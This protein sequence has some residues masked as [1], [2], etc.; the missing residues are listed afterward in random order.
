MTDALQLSRDIL[1]IFHAS[2]A[3]G[4]ASC[5]AARRHFGDRAD[6][7]PAT[8]G[9][10]PPDVT[11]KDIYL[12]DFS[13]KLDPMRRLI[14]FNRHVTVLDHHKTALEE[15]SP[16][17]DPT[18]KF[19]GW[20]DKIRLILDMNH[21]GGALAWRYFHPDMS[22]PWL[23]DYTEARDLWTFHL[24][25]SR[26]I[27][28]FLASQPFDHDLWDQFSNI[29]VDSLGWEVMRIEGRAILRYQDQKVEEQVRHASEIIIDGHTVL[30][31]NATHLISE[32]ANRLAVGRAFGAC[33]FIRGDGVKVWS[34]RST[35]GGVDVSE[36]ARRHGGGG[37]ARAASFTVPPSDTGGAP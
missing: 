20:Q 4:F 15:L 8:H 9:D 34:L 2:C 23:I 33:F 22:A 7:L 35:D 24:P 1:V 6:Y 36:I 17:S 12:L 3:D 25:Y 5:W 37:H 16:L 11:G 30:A 26:E 18:G 10:D 28:A 19:A 21:S 29:K 31:V 13:Y 27:N 14:S 32:I